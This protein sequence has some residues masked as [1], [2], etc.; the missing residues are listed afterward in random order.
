MAATTK[1]TVDDSTKG[2]LFNEHLQCWQ[3]IDVEG[4]VH[5]SGGKPAMIFLHG[6]RMWYHHGV[7]HNDNGPAWEIPGVASIWIRKGKHHRLDG[8][9]EVFLDTGHEGYAIDGISYDTKEEFI[10]ER[11]KYCEKHG[12]PIPDTP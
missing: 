5:R 1:E 11:N 12:I 10:V 8:P 2:A 9:A 3:W 6:K 7:P 4:R